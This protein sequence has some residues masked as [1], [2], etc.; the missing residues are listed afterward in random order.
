MRKAVPQNALFLAILVALFQSHANA[1]Q[2]TGLAIHLDFSTSNS[3]LIG[4]IATAKIPTGTDLSG[5]A[6]TVNV[7]GSGGVTQVF[8]LNSQGAGQSGSSDFVITGDQI[9]CTLFGTFG[10][11][12]AASGLVNATVT[13]KPLTIPFTIT[14]SIGIPTVKA[15]I[16]GVYSATQG[17]TGN[18]SAAAGGGQS[19]GQKSSPPIA[20]TSF[21]ATPNPAT[22]GAPVTFTGTVS[23]KV[24]AQSTAT[25]DP[26]D[27]SQPI[28][29]TSSN[30][31]ALNKGAAMYTYNSAG[32]FQ[33][34]LTIVGPNNSTTATVFVVV[35]QSTDVNAI[36]GLASTVTVGSGA[37]TLAI[38]IVRVPTAV[39][40]STTFSDTIG[41]DAPD[42]GLLLG[43][44]YA[45]PAISVATTTALD[46]SNAAVGKVRKMFAV[47]DRDVNS[48]SALPLPPSSA[49]TKTKIAGKF[50]FSA[51]KPDQVTFSGTVQLP[52]GFNPGASGGN[53]FVV[54]IGNV[55][56]SVSIDAKGKIIPPAAGSSATA[57]AIKTASVKYPRV[58][59]QAMGGE[60]ATFTATLS[61]PDLSAAGFDTEG[62]TQTLRPDES[63]FKA[64]NR[65][66]Q[67]SFLLGGVKYE[68]YFPVIYKLASNGSSGALGGRSA[69]H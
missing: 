45:A 50:F 32:A 65:F 8:V 42:L 7:G 24:D 5:N 34:T 56:G 51:T 31:T 13:N 61:A 19:G 2:A 40:A 39:T 15:S 46:A 26:G 37:I 25:L 67:T 1:A 3:D 14:F 6:A 16:K 41:R 63:K 30:L 29:I 47:S 64:V 27:G 9:S 53:V 11:A 28:A 69:V 23:G 33:A 60:S 59:G 38:S 21:T 52:A 17:A 66:V 4:V 12:L 36:N 22:I 35:G 20:I 62:I 58:A 55:V 57:S 18:F 49:L 68:G 43:R 44:S 54:G 48:P 10:S